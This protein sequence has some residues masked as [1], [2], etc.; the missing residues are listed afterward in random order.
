[1][2]KA[3]MFLSLYFIFC[4]PIYGGQVEKTMEKKSTDIE[5]VFKVSAIENKTGY[6]IIKFSP[7]EAKKDSE[8]MFFETD[9]LNSWIKVGEKLKIYTSIS[10]DQVSKKLKTAHVLV[11]LPMPRGEVKMWLLSRNQKDFDFKS[12]KYL[13]MHSPHTDYLIY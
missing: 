2:K 4:L 11:T 7:V 12:A 6:Y 3:W 10:R 8:D 1:M 9:L 5:G 13:N